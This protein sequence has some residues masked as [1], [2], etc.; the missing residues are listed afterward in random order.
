MRR[1]R[2]SA[3]L[4]THG[5]R[6]AKKRATYQD[7]LDA[8]PNHTAQILLGTLHVTPHRPVTHAVAASALGAE[9]LG[10]FGRKRGGIGGWVLLDELELHL[11]DEPDVVVPDIAGWRRERM[12][13]PPNTAA[14]TLPPDWICEVLSPRTEKIDR[15]DKTDI[16]AR[17]GVRHAWLVE[18][19]K[20]YLEV[21]RLESG[22][23]V[24]VAFHSGDA[25]V[26]A[27]PFEALALELDLLWTDDVPDA[28]DRDA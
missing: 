9:L 21:F 10:T 11:G 14:V 4:G 13:T 16:Y 2:R 23:W 18:P 20:K 7:V 5:R 24:R 25:V 26:N 3:I 22:R 27:E 28:A 19:V 6:R 8:P 1:C 17:E 12:P 15:G